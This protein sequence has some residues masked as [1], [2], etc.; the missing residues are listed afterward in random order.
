MK[1]IEKCAAGVRKNRLFSSLSEQAL[2][3]VCNDDG[4]YINSYQKDNTIYCKADF[5][6]AVGII[7]SGSVS[8]YKTVGKRRTLLNI[9]KE[10]DIFG[11]AS[12]FGEVESYVTAIVAKESTEVIFITHE[13]CEELVRSEPDFAVAYISFLSDRIRY[14]NKKI[15]SY[16]APSAAAKLA[17]YLLQEN[18]RRLNM[19]Q[20]AS[21]LNI[22]RASL[23]R[24][25]DELE[26]AGIIKKDGQDIQIID[27]NALT[28]ILAG[29]DS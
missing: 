23:Y 8:V 25:L 15:S 10:G 1:D 19:T 12:M 14:L 7:L 28:L 22:G 20:L 9:L 11:V 27:K 29:E 16:T 21:A 17:G 26:A 2:K 13:I 3:R 5:R 4:C 18:R 6:S 24:E